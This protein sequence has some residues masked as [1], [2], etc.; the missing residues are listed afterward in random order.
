M[1]A[2][3]F[4]AP[5][6]ALSGKGPWRLT[7]EAAARIVAANGARSADI[8][9]DF[10]HQALLAEQNGKPVPAAG[11]I[12]P[13]SLEFRA[14]GDEPGLYGAV[15]WVGDA[16]SLI[17][18]DE[19]RYLSPVFPYSPDGEPLDLLHVALTNFPAID[20]PLFAAL[21]ARFSTPP[22]RREEDPMELLNKLL[23]V[24]GLTEATSEADALAGVAALKAK[25]DTA[26]TEIAAL[27]AATP[28]AP[29]PTKFVPIETFQAERAERVRLASLSGAGEV[30]R[31]IDAAVS[32]GRLLENQ[33]AYA[34]SLG[35][36]DVAAL[37]GLID[38]AAPLAAL[39]G[40]QTQGKDLGGA[41]GVGFSDPELAVCK[42]MGLTAEQFS[43][44]RKEV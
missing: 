7:P 20:E 41:A 9:I 11:W 25:A 26:T 3:E 22:T 13:R 29:D 27:K 30:S 42:A 18:R 38:G 40:M 1:P 2:G 19:Y 28:A 8:L 17:A 12:D 4:S 39:K 24:L 37:K 31:L 21:S 15:T 32:D 16:A 33:R 44:A 10:E 34:E 43:A 5:R 36:A 14:E 23:A 35:R 6:G